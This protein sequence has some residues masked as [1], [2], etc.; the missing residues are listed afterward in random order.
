VGRPALLF[1]GPYLPAF[2]VAPDGRFLMVRVDEKHRTMTNINVIS[3]WF[4]ELRRR[5]PAK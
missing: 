3:G 5:V 1:E 2:D 4:D